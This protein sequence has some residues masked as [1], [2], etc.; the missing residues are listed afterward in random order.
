MAQEIEQIIEMLR[1]MGRANNSNSES[2][3]RLL[4]SINN[5]LEM[6]DKNA[7]TVAFANSLK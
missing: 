5:K 1:E 4:T 7:T 3:D 2:F 6:I